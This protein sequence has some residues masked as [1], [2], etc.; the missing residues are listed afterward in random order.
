MDLTLNRCAD[1]RSGEEVLA[2][3]TREGVIQGLA[4]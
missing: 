1:T 4:Y 3:R 2:Y